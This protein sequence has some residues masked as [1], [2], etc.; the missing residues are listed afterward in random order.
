LFT[1]DRDFRDIDYTDGPN[2]TYVK[3]PYSNPD[4]YRNGILYLGIAGLRIGWDSE[5]IRNYFQNTKVHDPMGI[6]RFKRTN[7]SGQPYF[8][9]G[10]GG[11]W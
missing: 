11:I 9:F 2:G 4:K 7:K 1:G 5:G 8:Q 10:S 3:G 6:P